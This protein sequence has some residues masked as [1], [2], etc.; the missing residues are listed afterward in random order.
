LSK[1]REYVSE[2]AMPTF[3]DFDREQN[4]RRAF[5]AAVAIFHCVD[6]AKEDLK[7][8]GVA[9]RGLRERWTHESMAFKLVDAVAHRFKHVNSNLESRK[10]KQWQD[11]L[12]IGDVLGRTN[13][14]TFRSVLIEALEFVE[15]QDKKLPALTGQPTP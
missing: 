14:A 15:K 7:A 3:Q 13:V 2:I 12:T 1:L 10:Q 9:S 5:L 6:R 8:A 11:Q 4:L